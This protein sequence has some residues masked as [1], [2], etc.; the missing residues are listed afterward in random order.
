MKKLLLTLSFCAVTLLAA[1]DGK[2]IV[3]EVAHELGT[4]SYYG[5]FDTLA[6][7]V[8]GSDVTL[9]GQVTRPALKN[10]A[11]QAVKSVEGVET[12]KNEIEVLP[13]SPSDDDVRLGAFRAI[14]GHPSLTRYAINSVLPVR[15]IVKNGN[16]E[17]MGEVQSEVDRT[18]I[19]TQVNS[20]P[21]A[22][23]VKNNVKVVK[24]K[25]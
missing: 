16:V 8:N 12:V 15:I 17:L 5:V 23:S 18:L 2:R 19:G 11:E 3:R 21:G 10:A 14:Y 4:L 6:Y 9:Y 22:L 25:E 24:A 13:L 7:R 20:V 1:V